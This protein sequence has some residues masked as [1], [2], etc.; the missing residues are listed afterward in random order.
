MRSE[1]RNLGLSPDVEAIR[2]RERSEFVATSYSERPSGEENT[3]SD[4]VGESF[5]G[6]AAIT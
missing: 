3:A 5:A 2:S 4:F 1:V 6:V